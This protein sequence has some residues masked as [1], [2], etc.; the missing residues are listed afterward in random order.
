MTLSNI[1]AS[2]RQTGVHPFDPTAIRLPGED[3]HTPRKSIFKQAGLA[4]IPLVSPAPK[5]VEK[6]LVTSSPQTITLPPASQKQKQQGRQS[7]AFSES[8]QKL[9]TTR[10]EEGYDLPDERY[11]LWLHKHHSDVCITVRQ[12]THPALQTIKATLHARPIRD[13]VTKLA[14]LPTVQAR[15]QKTIEHHVAKVLTDNGYI[16]ELGDKERKK[17][18]REE[19]KAARKE[20][21]EN[22]SR[23]EK[24]NASVIFCQL[25][26]DLRFHFKEQVLQT[27]QNHNR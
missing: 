12:P 27:L 11:N 13:T 10:L 24:S 21:E 4:Y 8:E 16:Q 19:Q 9:F 1:A 3:P 2:F 14:R 20:K 7:I 25:V 23:K 22:S 17:K 26:G 6:S 18:Q 15:S 5:G